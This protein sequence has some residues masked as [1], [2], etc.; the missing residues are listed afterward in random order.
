MTSAGIPGDPRRMEI[1]YLGIPRNPRRLEIDWDLKGIPNLLEIAQG[2]WGIEI[3][4]KG[5]KRLKIEID[6]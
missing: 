4:A 6:A 3:P 5:K 2:P 1:T